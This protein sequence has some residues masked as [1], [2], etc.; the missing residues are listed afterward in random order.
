MKTLLEAIREDGTIFEIAEFAQEHDDTVRA[1]R[2]F[3]PHIPEFAEFDE[4]VEAVER[5]LL[6]FSIQNVLDG[7]LS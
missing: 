2:S 4:I 6:R 3:L 1:V 7:E 5:E